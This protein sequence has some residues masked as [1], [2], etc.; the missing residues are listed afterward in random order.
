VKRSLSFVLAAALLQIPYQ[1]RMH[2]VTCVRLA[3]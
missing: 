3:R 1:R 2:D